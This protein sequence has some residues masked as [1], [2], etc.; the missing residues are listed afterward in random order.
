M[1]ILAQGRVQLSVCLINSLY[2]TVLFYDAF[3]ILPDRCT[4]PDAALRQ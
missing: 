2:F 3:Q 1:N 4:A